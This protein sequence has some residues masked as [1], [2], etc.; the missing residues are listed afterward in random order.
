MISGGGA[1]LPSFV[2]V[3][4]ITSLQ[5]NSWWWSQCMDSGMDLAY[6]INLYCR[7]IKIIFFVGY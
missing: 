3:F 2:P 7:P 1:A 4:K 5:Y 6:N